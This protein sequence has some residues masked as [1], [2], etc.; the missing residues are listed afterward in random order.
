[1]EV[2]VLLFAYVLLY[3]DYMHLNR[4]NHE[5]HIMNLRWAEQQKQVRKM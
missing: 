5:D 4:G 3:P 2:V 1:M